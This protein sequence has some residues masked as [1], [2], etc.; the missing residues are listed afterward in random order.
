MVTV[1][2]DCVEAF[3]AVCGGGSL[4]IDVPSVSWFGMASAD[5][6]CSDCTA[7]TVVGDCHAMA[8]RGSIRVVSD[9]VSELSGS[10]ILHRGLSLGSCV[11][12]GGVSL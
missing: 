2:S 4:H 8:E 11:M 3:A 6:R 1:V 10:W 7:V 12:A 9:V 5:I